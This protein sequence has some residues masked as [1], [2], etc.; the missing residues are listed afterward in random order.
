MDKFELSSQYVEID[1]ENFFKA[2]ARNAITAVYY[3]FTSLSTVGFGDLHPRSNAERLLV[4]FILLFGVAIFS[5]IMGIFIGIL[6]DAQAL[7]AE[8]D[9]GDEL[10][11]FFQVF[12]RFNGNKALPYKIIDE[13]QSFFEYKWNNDKNQAILTEKDKSLFL[14]LPDEVQQRLYNGFLF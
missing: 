7:G 8:F 1:P 11:K 9:E 3:A 4:A 13:I 12:A 10:T 14:Q 5:Y 2:D 6:N